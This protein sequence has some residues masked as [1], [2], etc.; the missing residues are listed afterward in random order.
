MRDQVC[1]F[2]T[3]P[4]PNSTVGSALLPQRLPLLQEEAPAARSHRNG[5]ENGYYRCPISA[6]G[7]EAP[8]SQSKANY[9]PLALFLLN[10]S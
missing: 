6:R 3:S 8:S 1:R 5:A 10:Y 4:A 9:L 2:S 7:I